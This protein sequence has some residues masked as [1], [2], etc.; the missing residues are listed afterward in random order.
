M[1]VKTLPGEY[2]KIDAIQAMIERHVNVDR[3]LQ[4]LTSA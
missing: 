3:L 4:R 2:E 1:T